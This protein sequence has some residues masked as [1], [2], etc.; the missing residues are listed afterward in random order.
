MS[1]YFLHNEECPKCRA[2]GNDRSKDNLARYSDGHAYCYK[3]SHYEPGDKLAPLKQEE[4]KV[5]SQGWEYP[6]VVPFSKECLTYLKTFGLTD[7]EITSNLNGHE[8][9]YSFFDSNFYLIRRL[10]KQPKVL[11][12]GKV[13]GNEP[14]FKSNSDRSTIVLCED[15]ISSIKVSRVI[16]SCSLLKTSCHPLLLVR[17]AKKYD[18]CFLWL[19]PDMHKHMIELR[20]TLSPYFKETRIILSDKDP[21]YYNTS[22]IKSFLT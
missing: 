16:D 11:V 10:N 22:Q 21:K 1:S 18:K 13:V 15:L 8:D 7:E 5:S 6:Q 3:C 20:E 9:G 12:K 4:V 14:V 2:Q 19:D 17:L